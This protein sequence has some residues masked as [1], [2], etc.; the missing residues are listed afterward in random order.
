MKTKNFFI[1][2]IDTGAGK[3]WATLAL[4]NY[5]KEQGKT[6]AG[7]KP[8]A[9][10]CQ[11]LDGQLRNEDALQLQAN[12]SAP[13]PYDWVNPYAFELPV[14][15]HLAAGNTSIDL[16]HIAKA[17]SRLQD[18]VEIVL[19]EGVGGWLV[20]LSKEYDIE[21]LVKYLDIPVIMTVGLRLG[22]INHAR[23]TWQVIQS[24][25]VDCV[26]WIAVCVDPGMLYLNENLQTLKTLIDVP[27]LGICPNQKSPVLNIS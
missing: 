25:G 9:S 19:V 21:D 1:T 24:S 10:G 8:V 7:M 23:M 11:W 20:P 22:C 14:A 6:V 2:G 18:R 17:F 13:L 3:T 26:G 15:P 16:N 4:M 27:M 5:V 12:A